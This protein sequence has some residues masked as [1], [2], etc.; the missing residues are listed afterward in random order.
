MPEETDQSPNSWWRLVY[1]LV[2]LFAV[3]VIL[4]LAGFSWFFSL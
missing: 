1:A 2:L 3:A 4:S